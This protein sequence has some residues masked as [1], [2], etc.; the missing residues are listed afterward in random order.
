[1]NVIPWIKPTFNNGIDLFSKSVENRPRKQRLN[2]GSHVTGARPIPG[3]RQ[4]SVGSGL[5]PSLGVF[6]YLLECISPLLGSSCFTVKSLHHMGC[7]F[8]G[9]ILVSSAFICL[10]PA[11]T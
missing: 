2:G 8:L 7:I 9:F 10:V 11:K 4:G 6:W 1:M 3:G 5:R